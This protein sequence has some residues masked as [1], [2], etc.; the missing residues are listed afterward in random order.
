[1]AKPKTFKLEHSSVRLKDVHPE[2]QCLKEFCTIHN[3]SK[4]HMR[5]LPQN[6]REDLG[7]MERICEH[8]V[9]HPDPDEFMLSKD[10][11]N[12]IHG[13]DGCCT[14]IRKLIVRK[15]LRRQGSAN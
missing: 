4:H 6:W 14:P 1:M 11:Y 12:S 10:I 5:H 13:C 7:I 9:G 3:R 8:G 2:D 15:D